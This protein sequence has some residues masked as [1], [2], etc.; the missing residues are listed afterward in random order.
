MSY[1]VCNV[2]VSRCMYAD[3]AHIAYECGGYIGVYL[4]MCLIDSIMYF[5]QRMY[6]CHVACV[7]VLGKLYVCGDDTCINTYASFGVY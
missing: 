7:R 1:K 2:Y 3:V 6:M 4:Y 5:I